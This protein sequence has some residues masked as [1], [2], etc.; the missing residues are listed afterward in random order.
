M[1]ETTDKIL[2]FLSDNLAIILSSGVSMCAIFGTIYQSKSQHNEKS[3]E[4]YFE[5]QLKA[6]TEFYNIA[7]DLERD[8]KPKESRDVRK[9]IAAA[10]NAELLSPYHVAV[11]IDNFCAVYLDYL[12]ES[13]IGEVSEEM[14]DD[15][16]TSLELVTMYLREEL[17]K[18][19]SKRTIKE[20]RLRK[21][22]KKIWKE[23]HKK[24]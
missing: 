23:V 24:E 15:F 13:D 2:S 8:L 22:L 5:A 20:K 21:K 7:S 19:D 17:L 16:K 3:M 6:Y 9:L 4:L 11:I 1:V 10:K 12:Y 14:H 18:Y